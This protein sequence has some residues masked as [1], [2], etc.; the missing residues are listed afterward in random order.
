[1]LEAVLN[2]PVP[3]PE[4]EAELAAVTVRSPPDPLPPVLLSTLAPPDCVKLVTLSAM[5]PAFPPPVVATE[6]APPSPMVKF[7]V[8]TVT[9]P[10]F[11]V[12]DAVLNNPVPC[13]DIEAE[14][15]ALAV[16]LPP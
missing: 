4:S 13:P 3:E 14:F 7:G 8:E 12:L 15:T 16:T 2:N 6:I 11:P 5:F 1:V 9:S 10:A